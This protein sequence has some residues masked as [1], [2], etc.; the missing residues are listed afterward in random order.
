MYAEYASADPGNIGGAQ[1][2]PGPARTFSILLGTA[3]NLQIGAWHWVL[4]R[5]GD[6]N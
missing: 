3:V 6:R 1:L 4:S 5:K 2:V